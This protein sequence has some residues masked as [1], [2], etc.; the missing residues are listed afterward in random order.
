MWWFIRKWW[1]LKQ[2][3]KAI[4]HHTSFASLD[5]ISR[6]AAVLL[7]E[8]FFIVGKQNYPGIA[9]K[10]IKRFSC[11]LWWR[12]RINE[13]RLKKRIH[14]YYDMYNALLEDRY[15]VKVKGKGEAGEIEVPTT[16][17]AKADSIYGIFGLL[18][19]ILTNYYLA[20]IMVVGPII[21]LIIGAYN[22]VYVKGVIN[23]LLNKLGISI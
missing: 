6:G 22:S 2:L 20:W 16:A 11:I 23:Y 17:T 15:I 19:A 7:T 18:Q 8:S 9:E 5:D 1:F 3:R 13:K 12:K 14:E 4:S 21:T 10:S